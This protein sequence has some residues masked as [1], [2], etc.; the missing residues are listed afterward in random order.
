[1][2]AEKQEKKTG[3]KQATPRESIDLELIREIPIRDVLEHYGYRPDERGW[4]KCM[5]HQEKS[6]SFHII[7]GKNRFKC[8]G[9]GATG[10][11]IDVVMKMDNCSVGEAVKHLKNFL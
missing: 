10:S 8:F 11:P 5:F 7:P 3:V 6:S 9:C 4:Y 1:M 2:K